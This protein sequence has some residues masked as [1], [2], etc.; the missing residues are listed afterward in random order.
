MLKLDTRDFSRSAYQALEKVKQEVEDTYQG[1][2]ED[3]NKKAS[4]AVQSL[5][6]Y[7]STWGLHRLAGDGLKYVN[8]RSGE[9]K[10]KGIVYQ[11]FLRNLRDLS[12]VCFAI[13]APKSLIDMDLSVYTGLNRLAISLAQEWSF[14]AVPILGEGKE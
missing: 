6:N 13:D 1:N 12:K 2:T 7:I 14:W 10:Y 5:P 4:A 8:S 3:Y 9:T 11:E